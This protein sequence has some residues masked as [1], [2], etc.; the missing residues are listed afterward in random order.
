MK[1]LLIIA[2]VVFTLFIIA[3]RYGYIV[4]DRYVFDFQINPIIRADRINNLREYR[5]VHEFIEMS[6]EQNLQKFAS[7]PLFDRLDV[8]LGEYEKNNPN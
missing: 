3:M 4:F 1:K 7:D 2:I 5:I 6:F 8:M